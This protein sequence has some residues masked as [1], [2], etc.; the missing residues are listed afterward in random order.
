MPTLHSH[1][2]PVPIYRDCQVAQLVPIH[3]E[4][5][6]QTKTSQRECVAQRTADRREVAH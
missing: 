3:R 2:R 6:A 1:T 5:N 4:A